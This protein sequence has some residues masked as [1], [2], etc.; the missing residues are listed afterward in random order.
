MDHANI[1][2]VLS[3]LLA[4]L[5]LEFE[6]ISV[7]D[8]GEFTRVDITANEPSRI[9][10]WHGETLNSLQHVLKA[11][12]RSQEGLEKSPFIVLDVDG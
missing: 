9:I 4:H 5:S 8:E 10:G 11:I 12:I 2:K 1:E 3:N 6:S 7:A